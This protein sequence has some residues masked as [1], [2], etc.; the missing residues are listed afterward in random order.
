MTASGLFSINATY[1]MQPFIFSTM[2]GPDGNHYNFTSILAARDQ[3]IVPRYQRD[4][5]WKPATFNKLVEDL[6]NHALEVENQQVDPYFLG[7]L[8]IQ[9]DEV[10]WYLVD[11]QQR[12]TALTLF[13]CAV[14]DKMLDAEEFGLAERLHNNLINGPNGFRYSP[15]LGSD[16]KRF[17]G[18]FQSFP[19]LEH[20]L[21]IEHDINVPGPAMIV[22]R[23]FTPRRTMP[24]NS[25]LN[26]PG[27]ADLILGTT[28]E[29]NA[30][31]ERTYF[32]SVELEEGQS[33]RAGHTCRVI[34]NERSEYEAVN[35][36]VNN[37]RKLPRHY[38]TA[39]RNIAAQLE[40]FIRDGQGTRHSFFTKIYQM[41]INL[42]FTTTEFTEVDDA[43]YYFEVMND[44]TNRLSLSAGDLFRAKIETIRRDEGN[45]TPE[46]RELIGSKMAVL[47]DTLIENGSH[48]YLSEFMWNWLLS[49]GKRVPKRKIWTFFQ[50]LLN[51]NGARVAALMNTLARESVLFREIYAPDSSDKEFGSMFPLSGILKQHHPI[52]LN[53]YSA[54]KDFEDDDNADFSIPVRRINRIFSYLVLRG[55]ILPEIDQKIPSNLLY[56]LVESQ[57][58]SIWNWP[59]AVENWSNHVNEGHPD[60]Q[61]VS[62]FIN[63]FANIVAEMVVNKPFMEENGDPIGH[64]QNEDFSQEEARLV[65]SYVEWYLRGF[66]EQ[67]NWTDGVE[68]EHVLPQNPKRYSENDEN[69]GYVHWSVFSEEEHAAHYNKLG[70]RALLP[71]G[72]NKKLRNYGFVTK[73]EMPDHGYNSRAAS[74]KLIE[75]IASSEEWTAGTICELS[76]LYA[77]IAIHIFGHDTFIHGELNIPHIGETDIDVPEIFI[78]DD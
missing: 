49:R 30:P 70:N 16:T 72:A 33:V 54:F 52:L 75:Y 22:V 62:E 74:W 9:K 32:S 39:K 26:I 77:R 59:D 8:I 64:F 53:V 35:G 57:C 61:S 65:L 25:R 40:E 66:N 50:Q 19:N 56:S 1:I 2:A 5:D 69:D 36:G 31:I 44:D 15:K 37:R 7:N 47:E 6:L 24:Q 27:V 12:T 58:K 29:V 11:G 41:L 20:E 3:L 68:V 4:Y 42:H 55:S 17:L 45:F 78:G 13:A 48:N 67:P 60:R 51:R 23:N 73:K 46:Q 10:N 43:I 76:S 28:L 14:R 38:G 63:N 71:E 34:H 18:F 21:V